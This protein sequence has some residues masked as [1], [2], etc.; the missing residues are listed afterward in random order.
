ME[1]FLKFFFFSYVYFKVVLIHSFERWMCS[2][3]QFYL[4]LSLPFLLL[5]SSSVILFLSYNYSP[6]RI[7][8]TFSQLPSAQSPWW[9]FHVSALITSTFCLSKDIFALTHAYKQSKK[10][11]RLAFICTQVCVCGDRGLI[12]T[13]EPTAVTS[14]PWR[15]VGLLSV[16]FPCTMLILCYPLG[17]IALLCREES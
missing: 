15:G 16:A 7:G 9:A 6:R 10:R 17:V 3:L 5:L 8:W 11:Y 2:R 12:E 14:H 13:S 1:R 4:S